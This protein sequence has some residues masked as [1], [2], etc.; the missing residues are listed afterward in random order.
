[1]P[2]SLKKLRSNRAWIERHIN[3]PFV[4]K[5]RREGYRARS[6]YKLTELDDTEH[7]FRPGMNVADLGS[8]PGSWTQIVRERLTDKNGELKGRIIAM[9]ILP[10]EPIDGVTFLQG[11]FREQE[12]A[13]K[14][15]EILGGDKLDVVISDMA[16]NLSGIAM[17]DANA[18]LLLNELALDFAV[19]HLKP[20]G[21]FVTK[22]FQGSG[23]S[24][25]IENCKKHF[26][27]VAQ[28]KGFAIGLTC[29]GVGIFFLSKDA[30]AHFFDFDSRQDGLAFGGSSAQDRGISWTTE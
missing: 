8:A 21:V 23:Y 2:K 17:V 16:P 13:D 28:R 29:F 7:L 20:E 15:N 12:V 27:S 26:V 6:V 1:M 22:A 10:M 11:D 3:D 30:T 9:D 14:L 5:S 18:S 24:Q 25:F 19:E 4:K